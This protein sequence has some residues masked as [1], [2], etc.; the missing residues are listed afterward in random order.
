MLPLLVLQYIN[1]ILL[2]Y[3]RA[4]KVVAEGYTVHYLSYASK[5]TPS[6]LQGRS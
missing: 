4:V 1:E 3:T 5:M 6:G 2:N